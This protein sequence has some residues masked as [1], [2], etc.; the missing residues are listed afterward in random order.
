MVVVGGH[1]V[2]CRIAWA[3]RGQTLLA[4][5]LWVVRPSVVDLAAIGAHQI[6]GVLYDHQA[7]QIDD[8]VHLI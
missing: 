4:G 5:V 2:D 1:H 7:H 3:R 8:E 6:V